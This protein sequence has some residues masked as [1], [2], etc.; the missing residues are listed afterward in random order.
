MDYYDNQYPPFDVIIVTSHFISLYTIL[1]KRIE[2]EKCTCYFQ[3]YF[4]L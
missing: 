1:N 4:L 3:L 2:A